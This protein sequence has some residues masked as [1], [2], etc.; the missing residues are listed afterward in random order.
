MT[1]GQRLRMALEHKEPDRV[2]ID[3]G[4]SPNSGIT[5]FAYERLKK[6]LGIESPTRLLDK[7]FQLA[8]LSQDDELLERLG[9]D[10]RGV[11]P[12]PHALWEDKVGPGD[13]YEDEWGLVRRRPPGG[14][15]YDVVK[16]PFAEGITPG[17][18]DKYPWPD[19]SHPSRFVG[20]AEEITKYHDE[21]YG[22]VVNI[23]GG[24][25]G[26]S[27]FLRGF[28]GW[29]LDLALNPEAICDLM[30]ITLQFQLDLI[31]GMLAEAGDKVDVVVYGDDLATQSDLM[32]SPKMYREYLK[33]R[34][35]KLFAA[36][37]KLSPA[38][39][40]YHSCGSIVSVIEDLIEIGVEVLNPIQVSARGM[41]PAALKKDFGDKLS[42]WGGIDTQRVLPRGTVAEVEAEVKLRI[43]QMA[44]G[45]GYVLNPVHNIQADVPPE[46]IVAL[47][48]TGLTYGRYR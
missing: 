37:R 41:D 8:D 32:V 6:H 4:S 45:G 31:Q 18:L 27:Q 47:F 36:I 44:A 24:F 33:P 38:K 2:P 1:H 28:E 34:Q 9:V 19:G 11:F 14:L 30:D 40:H 26:Q 3:L 12:R 23:R 5:I 16:S 42:F 39:I 46:N 35:A 25:I 17:Q 21:G 22:V 10:T 43:D 13:S 29:F 20:V 15:Y 48:D 7:P